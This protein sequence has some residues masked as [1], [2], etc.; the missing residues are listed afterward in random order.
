MTKVVSPC[1]LQAQGKKGFLLVY[2][3]SFSN[4][5]I[6]I[7]ASLLNFQ[8]LIKLYGWLLQFSS[9]RESRKEK[10]N[11]NNLQKEK[12]SGTHDLCDGNFGCDCLDSDF[13]SSWPIE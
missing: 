13:T 3:R 4:Q 5:I 11:C 7:I 9:F 10:K 2:S 6:G 12:K 8:V 1:T